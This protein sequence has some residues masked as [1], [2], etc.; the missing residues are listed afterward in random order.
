MYVFMCA[1]MCT[2]VHKC[3]CVT[4][5]VTLR[6]VIHLFW[7]TSPTGLD[8]LGK[9]D[10]PVSIN[11]LLPWCWNYKYASSHLDFHMGSTDKTK[12]SAL[13]TGSSSQPSRYPCSHGLDSNWVIDAWLQ[14]DQQLIRT[15]FQHDNSRS[16]R[17][18]CLNAKSHFKA[19]FPSHGPKQGTEP[20]PKLK[21]RDLHS[22]WRNG[23][24]SVLISFVELWWNA[25][26][27]AWYKGK[28][29]VE[30]TVS[31]GHTPWFL[32]RA[33]RQRVS[34]DRSSWERGHKAK[35]EAGEQT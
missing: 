24:V 20:S 18:P 13:P 4:T 3:V 1:F 26:D 29:S 35:H 19:P 25:Q 16:T 17:G 23:K 12:A 14:G 34:W 6:N 21:M 27:W 30:V 33:M 10:W 15:C 22:K 8:Q 9:A 5:S 32:G 31:R 28:R 2:C 11:V 7:V